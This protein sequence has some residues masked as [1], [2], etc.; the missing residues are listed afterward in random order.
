MTGR[1]SCFRAT[2]TERPTGRVHHPENDA[3]CPITSCPFT[4]NNNIWSLL[5]YL[6]HGRSCLTD[7]DRFGG[8]QIQVDRYFVAAGLACDIGFPNSIGTFCGIRPRSGSRLL[9]IRAPRIR[10]WCLM[11]QEL[12]PPISFT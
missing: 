3:A 9:R 6:S 2:T 12:E 4:G 5:L 10:H 8:G 7:D 11:G 1:T